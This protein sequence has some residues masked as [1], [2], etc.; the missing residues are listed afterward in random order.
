MREILNKYNLSP[1]QYYFLFAIFNRI[2]PFRIQLDE[3]EDLRKRNFI[4]KDDSGTFLTSTSELI[5]G[6]DR[7]LKKLFNEVW[8]LYP[9]KTPNGRLLRPL[10]LDS[11][12]G[13]KAFLKLKNNLKD[14]NNHKKIIKALKNEINTRARTGG[15]NYMK[16]INTWINQKAWEEYITENGSEE[17]SSVFNIG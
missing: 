11:Q 14:I 17:G 2:P 12:I 8:D 4:N 16:H 5:F 15:L 7:D 6:A 1:N 9:M 10:S 3:I 13:K